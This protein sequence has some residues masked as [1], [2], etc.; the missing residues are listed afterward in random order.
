MELLPGCPDCSYFRWA[1]VQEHCK[2]NIR[3]DVDHLH[4]DP[5]V[6]WELTRLDEQKAKPSYTYIVKK[7]HCFWHS[8]WTRPG[9]G[10]LSLQGGMQAPVA[11]S[12]ILQ[13]RVACGLA[14]QNDVSCYTRLKSRE[15]SR[16]R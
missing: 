10:F 12:S 16:H 3:K 2:I 6:L 13:C 7:D 1:D 14:T 9:S 8:F 4:D 11:A 5:G 15:S